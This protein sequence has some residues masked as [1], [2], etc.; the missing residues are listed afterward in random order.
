MRSKKTLLKGDVRLLANQGEH[1]ILRHVL[2]LGDFDELGLFLLENTDFR[3][4][5]FDGSSHVVRFVGLPDR[6]IAT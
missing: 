4:N 2:L 3:L 5:A 1:V 6:I